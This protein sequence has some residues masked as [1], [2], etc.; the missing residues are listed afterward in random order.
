MPLDPA[1]WTPRFER[2]LAEQM[3]TDAAHDLAHVRRVAAAAERLARAEGAR[4]DVVLPA[5]WLHDCVLLPKD[6][7][8]RAQAS[9]LAAAAAGRWLR[10]AGY[11]ADLV[12]AVEHAVEAHS[13]S[14][15]VEPRTVEAAVVQDADRLEALG[16][17]GIARTFAVGGVLGAALYHPD[18]PFPTDRALDDRRY[19]VDHF[20]AKLLTLAATMRTAAGRREAERRTAFLHAFLDQLRSEIVGP[21]GAQ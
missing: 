12:P 4:L 6:H 1:D 16:A 19:A 15:N 17:I 10:A 11:P 14:A 8:E 20:Y 5:A 3:A 13:F 9:A 18:D 2:F 7:P 21:P